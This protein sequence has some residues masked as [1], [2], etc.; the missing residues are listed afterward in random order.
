MLASLPAFATF[1]HEGVR[2]GFEFVRFSR[3]EP[4]VDGLVVQGGVTATEAGDAWSLQYRIVVNA[5]WETTQVEAHSLTS[6]SDHS[7]LLAERRDGHW[8]VNGNERPDLDG[9]VD[10]DFEASVA[11]NTLAVRRLDLD[12]P[13][14]QQVPA[15]FVRSGDLSVERIEQA[16]ACTAHTRDRV[17]FDYV[18]TTFGL[19]CRLDFDAAGVLVTYPDLG[20]RHR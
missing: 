5:G 17:R 20:R 4:A 6:S 16:Y 14:L 10:V 19:R 15:A 9:C 7:S 11:T 2:D 8:T 13:A 1:F 12:T 3:P 18:S